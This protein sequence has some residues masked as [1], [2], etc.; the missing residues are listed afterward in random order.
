MYICEWKQGRVKDT[1]TAYSKTAS[2]GAKGCGG[3]GVTT[4]KHSIRKET[5]NVYRQLLRVPQYNM[6]INPFKRRKFDHVPPEV[7]HVPPKIC[8]HALP[9]ITSPPKI[10]VKV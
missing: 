1:A 7:D 4:G 5:F 2:L 6:V 8:G 10:C 9:K 3:A